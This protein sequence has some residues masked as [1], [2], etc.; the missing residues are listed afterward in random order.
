MNSNNYTVDEILQIDTLPDIISDKLPSKLEVLRHIFHHTRELRLNVA[1]S[2]ILVINNVL[3]IWNDLAIPVRE[4]AHCVKKL[5]SL[6]EEYRTFQKNRTVSFLK[7]LDDLF[8]ISHANVLNTSDSIR[9]DF[10]TNQ[11][12]LGRVGSIQD[13]KVKLQGKN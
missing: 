1:E 2:S 7:N 6:Y 5:K 13:L 3:K 4:K 12:L 9:I 8:D 11:K 10:L